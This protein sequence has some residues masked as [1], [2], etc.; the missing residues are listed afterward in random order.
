MVLF[1]N[2]GRQAPYS[3]GLS[4]SGVAD[5]MVSLGCVIAGHLDGG[6]STTFV[7]QHEGEDGLTVRNRPSDTNERSVSTAL[8]VTSSA[9]PSGVFDHDNLTPNNELYTPG[10]SVQFAATGVDSAGSAA[11]LPEDILFSV[12]L[13]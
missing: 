2:D 12:L 9:T 13:R 4:W 3:T 10:S 11:P 6:G 1:V 5:V 8:L 7:S